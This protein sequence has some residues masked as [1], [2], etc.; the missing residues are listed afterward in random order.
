MRL[1]F[2]HNLSPT[3]V[4]SLGDVYPDSVHVREVDL[5]SADDDTVWNYA[6]QHQLIIVSKDADFH[7]RSFVRGHPPK[8]IWIRLGNC[9]TRDIESLLR[10]YRADVVAFVQDA[11]ASFLA[12]G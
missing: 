3:L 4:R 9:K 11:E 12:L 10:S 7:Q 8:I 6:T 2:D 5:H 1:L